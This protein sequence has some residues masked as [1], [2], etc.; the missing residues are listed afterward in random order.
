MGDVLASAIEV[1]LGH[2]VP[3]RQY[4][5]SGVEWLGTTP[6]HWTTRPLKR[7]IVSGSADGSLIKGQMHAEPG[8]RLF[9][10]FSASGQDIWVDEAQHHGPGIVVSAVGARC[11]KTFKADGDWTAVANTHVL[12]PLPG[13]DRDFLWYVTNNEAFWDRGG[14]AQPF[15]RV[16]TTLDRAWSFPPTSE[17][18]RIATFL[19]RET[20]RIDALVAKKERLIELLLEKRSALITR[21]VTK[22]L[23]PNVAMKRSG[24]EWLGEIPSHWVVKRLGWICKCL[25]GH[26]VPLNSEERGQMQGEYPYWGANSVVDHVD[27]WIFDQELVLLGE[28]GAPFFERWKQVAFYVNGKVWVNNHA[29]VLMPALGVDHRFLVHVLN[30]VEYRLFIDGSTRD[31]LTQADMNAIPIQL[32]P[33]DEQVR[34]RREIDTAAEKI[35]RL[36]SRV[37]NGIARA[38]ELRSALISAAVTGKIDVREEVA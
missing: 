31:K 18:R 17:Q 9:P 33:H 34:I 4:K 26:R 1:R 19:D 6:A 37:R 25:D 20:A 35:D 38:G 30:C 15:V 23:D 3:Y 29:H 16:T 10:G 32:P 28:D 7:S 2:F 11:G 36:I 24:V 22:G 21:A 8:D 5:D 13:N 12:F 27:R 14:T